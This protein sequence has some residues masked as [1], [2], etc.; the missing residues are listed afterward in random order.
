MK[1]I[2]LVLIMFCV[3]AGNAKAQTPQSGNVIEFTCNKIT[4]HV[5]D[6]D[7]FSIIAVV[8]GSLGDTRYV[9]LIPNGNDIHYQF[10]RDKYLPY[11]SYYIER[12]I[13]HN[14]IYDDFNI[15]SENIM[16]G[17]TPTKNTKIF[18]PLVLH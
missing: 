4:L 5:P 1:K 6:N 10:W 8:K 16:C 17:F 2:M 14:G 9:S 7:N 13:I 3:F 18:I 15:M 12:V 11:A